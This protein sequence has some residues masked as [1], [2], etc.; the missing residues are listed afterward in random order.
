[1]RVDV[2]VVGDRTTLV[3]DDLTAIIEQ[4]VFVDSAIVLDGQVV[5][6]RNLH[7]VK[8][9]YILP[10]VFKNMARQHGAHSIPEPMIQAHRRTVIHHP[11]PD[12]RFALGIFRGIHISVI[13]RLKRGVAWVKRVHQCLL[14]QRPA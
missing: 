2:C 5:S 12:Q 7:P 3:D 14:R 9:F 13:L 10:A 6:E 11:E 4:N 1:M 8:D